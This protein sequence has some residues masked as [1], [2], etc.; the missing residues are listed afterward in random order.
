[1]VIWFNIFLQFFTF[2]LWRGAWGKEEIFVVFFFGGG[3][4]GMKK[5]FKVNLFET[6]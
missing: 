5:M 3:I 4:S 6:S 2:S 1:M